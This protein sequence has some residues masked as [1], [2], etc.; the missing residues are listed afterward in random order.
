MLGARTSRPHLSAKREKAPW[1]PALTYLIKTQT[2]IALL[3][4]AT[5]VERSKLFLQFPLLMMLNHNNRTSRQE[6]ASPQPFEHD[7]I[8]RFIR[9]IK[10]DNVEQVRIFLCAP[11]QKFRRLNADYFLF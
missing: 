1:S 5:V 8:I 7:F 9:W 2:R 4:H 3:D 11:P 6:F 10:K